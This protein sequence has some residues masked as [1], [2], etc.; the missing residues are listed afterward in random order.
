[1]KLQKISKLIFIALAFVLC[2]SIMGCSDLFDN[3][4]AENSSTDT[5]K[6]TDSETDT[7]LN[8]DSDSILDSNLTTDSDSFED[9]ETEKQENPSCYVATVTESRY[10]SVSPYFENGSVPN[11]LKG[12]YYS[13]DSPG[14]T[15]KKDGTGKIWLKVTP[16]EIYYVNK[17]K[18]S[19]EYSSVESLGND[20]YCIHGV[21]S[22][23]TVSVSV[24]TLESSSLELFENFGYG[25]SDDGQLVLTWKQNESDPIRYV[26]MKYVDDGKTKTEY[27]DASCGRAE[28]FKMDKD[29]EYVVSIRAVGYEKLGQRVEF[30]SCYM[31]S[32][33]DV[34]FPRVEIT[35]ENLIWPGCDFV[36]SPEGCWGAGI[37]NAFYE[38][39]VMTVY[40]KDNNVVYDSSLKMSESEKYLG[41]KMK[42]RGNT[43]AA[44]A[45]NER[46][47]YK[48]KLDS[49]CDLLRPLVGRED[50]SDKYADKDWLLLNYGND[51]Y[52]ICGDA[53][54]DAVGT[55][56][57]PDYCYVTLYVNGEY[58]GLYV[59]SEAVEEGSGQGE[60][61]W[62]VDVDDDGF[63][64]EC[65]AYWWNE[66]I[67]FSTPLSENTPMHFTFKYP[68]SDNLTEDSEEYIYLQSY[69][70]RF[71]EALM[72][73]DDSYLDYIDLDSFVKW[74]LV[75]DYLCI[76][77][78]GGCNIF[79]YKEDSTDN[80]KI[81]MGPNWDF[82]SY[83]G[84]TYGL[85]TIRLHW[86]TAP[87]YYQYLINKE[88]F[89]KRYCELFEET[90][91]NLNSKID[92]AFSKIDE[93][94]HSQ[95]L[96]YDRA[97]FGTSSKTLSVRK[98]TFTIWLKEHIEWMEGEFLE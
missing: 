1:M 29:K 20:V 60:D 68:D 41:A 78:G 14:G 96:K 73:D 98:N 22:N 77:D 47:P 63:V 26:E 45:S 17:I 54:A 7:D 87:F 3:E 9:V 37:T 33:K 81:A 93:E 88:S 51:A 74:L 10:A 42:I 31:T 91:K 46:Y 76:N 52:R 82:D 62:R 27:L 18:V 85:S 97:R 38:Q 57:S 70:T 43:S 28:T 23:L 21:K 84:N 24:K 66:E 4:N 13:S 55:E 44:H 71:E 19:G 8:S 72:R 94:A 36:G 6:I 48:I 86:D 59:L 40:D 25:I 53:I 5:E 12:I 95:L 30:K 92:E 79:L 90:Y 83:M 56:W 39:C 61:K 11:E 64:F 80:T 67:S 89:H 50:N 49:K 35:T 15:P 75:S 65:D 32:P 69:L 2:F 16:K 34:S 58:R